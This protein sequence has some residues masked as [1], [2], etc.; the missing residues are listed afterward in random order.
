MFAE[1][2]TQAEIYAG[3][4]APL[5]GG[6]FEGF[7][8]TVFAYGQTASGKTYTMM[9]AGGDAGAASDAA[10]RRPPRR[11][12]ARAAAAA[13]RP[14][15]RA[16]R[17]AT[18][19]AASCRACSTT[20]LRARARGARA[21]GAQVVVRA[22]YVEILNEELRDLLASDAGASAAAAAAPRAR[23]ARWAKQSGRAAPA[24][25]RVAV[26]PAPT[27]RA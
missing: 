20:C 8:A 7:N 9:G 23:A 1:R 5:V 14:R 25:A 15:A 27:A 10:A 2:A 18:R 22:S 6:A 3:V 21:R 11:P 17:R 12:R 24:A 26:R 13:R 19:S 16:R 4:V